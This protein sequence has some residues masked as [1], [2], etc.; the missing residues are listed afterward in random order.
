M[1][2]PEI[3]DTIREAADVLE[4]QQIAYIHL[5]EADGDDAPVVPDNFRELLRKHYAN[6]IIV[7]GH[8]NYARATQILDAGHADLVAFDRPFVANPDLPR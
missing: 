2:D 7:A 4:E 6:T 3:I 8:H 1:A 5:S